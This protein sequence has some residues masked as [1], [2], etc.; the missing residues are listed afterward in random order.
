[1]FRGV[2][3][4][5]LTAIWARTAVV[6]Q[7]VL[8]APRTGRASLRLDRHADGRSVGFCSATIR[9][10]TGGMALPY[11]L[12]VTANTVTGSLAVVLIR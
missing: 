6:I 2:F 11:L 1:M 3:L 5:D 10:L 8:L 7:T 12:H 4:D 9:L